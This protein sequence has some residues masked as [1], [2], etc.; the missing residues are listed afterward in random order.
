MTLFVCVCRLKYLHR[1]VLSCSVSQKPS[2]Q[3]PPTGLQSGDSLWMGVLGVPTGVLGVP[4]GVLGVPTGVL[5]V[6]TGVLCVPTCRGVGCA[7]RGVG[8]VCCAYINVLC[9]ADVSLA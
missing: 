8:W 7:Y 2:R 1:L 4:T 6:P 3:A 9:V 5:S